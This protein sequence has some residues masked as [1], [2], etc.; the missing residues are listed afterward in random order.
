MHRGSVPAR[1]ASGSLALRLLPP[2]H[3]GRPSVTACAGELVILVRQ[4]RGV[5]QRRRP[6][7]VSA[8]A[9]HP[10]SHW[11]TIDELARHVRLR[12]SNGQG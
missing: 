9:L 8:G 11:R 5:R 10:P 7:V 1:R 2:V 6:R 12:H 4:R 3:R